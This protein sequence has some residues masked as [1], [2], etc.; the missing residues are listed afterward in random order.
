MASVLIVAE[1]LQTQSAAEEIVWAIDTSSRGTP[2]SPAVASVKQSDGT[3]KKSTVMPV[4]SASVSN[5]IISLP[6]L[7]LLTAGE[8]YEIRTTY[9]VSG[10][11]QETIINVDCPL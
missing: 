8:R 3:D 6:T 10:N 9:T 5:N 2:T 11:K 1:G 4:G 7:K